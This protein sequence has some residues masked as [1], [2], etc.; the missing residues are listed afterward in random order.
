MA[1]SP[2]F[3]VD[4]SIL[5]AHLRQQQPTVFTRSR[6]LYGTP[7]VS[8]AVI[9]ELEVG[10]RRAGRQF[11]FHTHFMPIQT[12]SL[13]QDVLFQAAQLQADLLKANQVIGLIDT[14]VAATALY[15]QLPLLTLNI[16]HF[17]RVS[18]LILLTVP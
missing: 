9:F 16:K 13:S 17:Q 6:A 10:A 3:F 18:G 12:Y 11:D 2:V 15:Y 14:F 7:V 4:T 8:D 5:I 1:Q